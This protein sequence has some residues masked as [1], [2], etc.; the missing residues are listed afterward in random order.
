MYDVP[1]IYKIHTFQSF[2][3]KKY[4]LVIEIDK[5]KDVEILKH[6]EHLEKHIASNK[7]HLVIDILDQLVL[8]KAS[9]ELLKSTRIGI[10][11]NDVRKH[12]N[13][14]DKIKEMAKKC[15]EKWKNDVSDGRKP[16]SDSLDNKPPS[17]PSIAARS[18]ENED[19]VV[20]R[21]ITSDDVSFTSKGDKIR[22]RCIG[23]LYAALAIGSDLDGDIIVRKA[24][25][26]EQKVYELFDKVSDQY[27]SKIRSLQ[28]NLKD[29]SNTKLRT[30]VLHGDISPD[31]FVKMSPEELASEEK[32]QEIEDAHKQ[33]MMDAQTAADQAAETD[34]FRC[35]KCK[36][37][38][39][40]YY[41]MQTR[42]A[43]E[44]MTT[45]VTCLNCG[46]RWKF[47]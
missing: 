35:G 4:N 12:E 45:F 44:P 46:H 40:K 38:R 32:K 16:S 25:V 15:I 2:T 36:Q 26:V 24:M 27:K 31:K 22:D 1:Q 8:W 39:T 42:S 43:D 33:N 18:A 9:K 13:A 6:R 10:V 14:N 19:I 47:C 29:K 23:M 17:T 20:E 28:F 11:V 5:M 7:I 41:Q 37:R 3:L 34:Q 21:T 30:R